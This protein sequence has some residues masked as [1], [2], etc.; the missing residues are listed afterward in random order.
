MA[1][2]E[3]VTAGSSGEGYG[4]YDGT[5]SGESHLLDYVRVLS[6]RRWT[7]LTVFVIV[8][9]TA[10]I[11]TFTT[12]PIYRARTQLLIEADKPNIVAF[13]E[14]IEERPSADFYPTQY[15]LL[16]SR[17]LA[18]RTL[19]SLKLWDHPEFGGRASGPPPFNLRGS[20]NQALGG[21]KSFVAAL[22]TP[23]RSRSIEPAAAEETGA[24]AAA[25]DALLSRL[26]ISPVRNSRLVDV[27]YESPD[28]ALAA[29]VLNA[30]ARM[31]IE[32][33]LEFKFLASKE[34]SDWLGQRLAEERK[35]VE[36]AEQA[37]QRY[38]EQH[39]SVSLE[40]RQN[41]V[42][43]KLT[44]LNSAVTRAK[45]E[46][47]AK[48][49]LYNQL[50][51]LQSDPARLDTF[52]AILLNPLIQQL[53]S[54]L[55]D[56]QRQHAQLSEQL[57]EKHPDMAKVRSSIQ[58]TEAKLQTE[59]AKVAQAVRNEYQAADDQEQS[60][61]R[62][63]NDQKRDALDLNQIGI[64]YGVLQRNAESTRQ[65]YQTLLQRT[66]ETNVSGELK[67]SN[68]RI[69]DAAEAP[70]G[71]V[72]PNHQ[73][74]M[75]M[76]FAGGALFAIVLAFFFEYMD[77][78]IKA[79]QDIKAYLGLPFLGFVPAIRHQPKGSVPL[80]NNGVPSGFS[81]AFRS[82]RTNVLFSSASDAT[83]S[84]VVTSTAPREGKTLVASNLAIGLAQSGLRVLLMDADLRRPRV[85]EAF[86]YDQEPGLSNF[87][88]GR[89][90]GSDVV[91]RKSDVPGLYVLAAGKHPP[92]PAELLGSRRF[93]EF[94]H[95]LGQHF[96]WIVI[97]SPP[98]LPVTDASIL[99]HGATGVVFVVGAEMTSRHA[100]QSA[101]EQLQKAGAHMI[102][103]VLNRVRLDRNRYYYSRHYRREY[104]EYYTDSK[105]A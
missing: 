104:T 67:T 59:I 44:D 4:G 54:Q 32:Q 89:Q 48:Q 57:G 17:S 105:T 102:G 13:K 93:I 50:I 95:S 61:T 70:Q 43:Q 26:S 94:V 49:T 88:V 74:D 87:L 90:K 21:A 58:T 63:L 10:T 12:T 76:G 33:S 60:L 37:L 99:A 56:V 78:R 2:V 23:A 46:R 71:P 52:P 20:V 18:R 9:V 53:K 98:V 29:R 82:V 100:A 72:R 7:A 34:A 6:K 65:L 77:N 51:A 84:V 36:A 30:L 28:P 79:P 39:A 16:R 8:T 103:V 38:R 97:D 92:N 81:E 69:V 47:V 1:M 64:E 75:L 15:A 101:V 40:D 31:Y 45:T 91:V 83:R 42:V 96:D 19:D 14:V 73:S 25:I 85:H 24:Q 3:P 35:K 68:V 55:T 86:G 80:L 5:R 62:M 22:V 66:N 27:S 41:I 11:D